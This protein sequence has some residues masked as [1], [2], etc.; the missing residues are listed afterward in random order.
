[1]SNVLLFGDQT[2]EQYPLLRKTVL[3]TGNASLSTFLERTSA[4]LRDEIKQLAPHQRKKFPDFMTINNLLDLYYEAG[5]K[6]PMLESAF[7]TIAQ[8]G[9]FIGY[10]SEHPD[11]LP[12]M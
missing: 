1:M 2:A 4:A 12:K 5:E 3:R 8:L 6:I 11:E 7:T 10:F 9:H